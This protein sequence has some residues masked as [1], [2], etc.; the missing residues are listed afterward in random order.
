MEYLLIS[1]LRRQ[2]FHRIHLLLLDKRVDSIIASNI[3]GHEKLVIVK[4]V[5]ELVRSLSR[6]NFDKDCSIAIFIY[7]MSELILRTSLKNAA[8]SFQ[9]LIA[10]TM[11]PTHSV[12]LYTVINSSLHD[13]PTISYL[14]SMVDAVVTVVPNDGATISSEIAAELHIVRRSQSSTKITEDIEMFE[15]RDARLQPRLQVRLNDSA[16]DAKSTTE[17]E[18]TNEVKVFQKPHSRLITFE[19]TDP[20]FDDDDDPDADLDL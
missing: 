2:N 17:H 9:Q 12:N 18:N 19:S 13:L 11:N 1:T 5:E 16:M 20:E 10:L 4:S 8:S 7:S 14:T 15:W 3:E 6:D